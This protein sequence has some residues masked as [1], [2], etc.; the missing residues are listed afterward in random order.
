VSAASARSTDLVVR[1]DALHL[2][3]WA[4]AGSADVVYLDPPFSVGVQFRARPAAASAQGRRARAAGPS[5]YDDRWPSLPAY[6]EW[7]TAR[8]AVARDA[9]APH[10]TLWLHLDQR[11]VHEAKGA[12]D[13]LF[14]R[15]GFVG[16]IIW[17]PGNGT[18]TRRGPGVSHQTILVYARS[19]DFLWNSDDPALRAPYAATSQAM[20]F[21][22]TDSDGRAY[23]ERVIGSRTY[24]YYADQ[25]RALGSV[26]ADCPSMVANTP[27][28]KETTGYPTQ[29]PRKLLDRIVRAGSAPGGLVIDPFHGSGT[30]LVAAAA[31]G[32][33]FVGMDIGEEAHRIT[34]A[35]LA[36]EQIAFAVAS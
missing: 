20:H 33:R 28:R 16:E 26:W 11:A 19:R 3:R 10:G 36:S 22:R 8:L 6:L 15:G 31:L 4:A 18:K 25:G 14:G 29:K 27:L 9:L 13:A 24:R 35:R 30:T 23:R 7:L 17:L 1:D 34:C 2:L 12:L 21:T 32:R 5:V